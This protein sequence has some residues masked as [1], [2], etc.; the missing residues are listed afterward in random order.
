MA[1]RL[2]DLLAL[3]ASSSPAVVRART[4]MR[5]SLMAE[6]I[7][8]VLRTEG[9]GGR[10][11]VWAHNAHV[12]NAP[13]QPDPRQ[14]PLGRRVAPT[15]RAVPRLAGQH[16]RVSLGASEVIIGATASR[17][18]GWPESPSDSGSFDAAL[19]TVGLPGFVLDLRTSDRTP[20]VAS[21]LRRRW[22]FRSGTLFEQ[23]V[24][25]E[26]VDAIV[27]FDQVT[28]TKDH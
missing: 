12:M 18:I 14:V 24:P 1:L 26:A 28:L 13:Y 19:A 15:D 20:E 22:P 16:L 27:Y 9:D 6:N 25:R 5:D 2:N 8:W 21:M 3:T 11:L 4:V 17:T 7:R 23:I 10:V